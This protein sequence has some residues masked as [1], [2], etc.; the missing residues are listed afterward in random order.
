[1][2]KQ[3]RLKF[4]PLPRQ[5]VERAAIAGVE[6]ATVRY[7]FEHS[8]EANNTLVCVDSFN[9]DVFAHATVQRVVPVPVW[10]ALDIIQQ[11][12]ALYGSQYVEELFH[13][14][15]TYYDSIEIT[16][17]VDVIIYKSTLTTG[18]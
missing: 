7:E 11:R 12:G 15:Q 4:N 3:I 13:S 8:I 18:E 16:D 6:G 14:L 9:D 2:D 1:M 5:T 10:K 17:T